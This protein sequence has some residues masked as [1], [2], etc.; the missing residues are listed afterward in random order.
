MI[1]R[2]GQSQKRSQPFDLEDG[3]SIYASP[4]KKQAADSDS[5]PNISF[6]EYYEDDVAADEEFESFVKDDSANRYG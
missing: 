1:Y 6:Q 3:D 2:C 5:D 4:I